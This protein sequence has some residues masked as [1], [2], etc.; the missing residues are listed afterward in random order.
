MKLTP[1]PMW[2]DRF[3]RWFAPE[4]LIAAMIWAIPVVAIVASLGNS[5]VLGLVAA[6]AL[7][8]RA[9]RAGAR[10]LVASPVGWAALAYLGWY[11]VTAAWSPL[12][13]HGVRAVL[14]AMLIAAGGTLLLALLLGAPERLQR[15]YL[16]LVAVS[17]LAFVVAFVVGM[18]LC[19]WLPLPPAMDFSGEN[20]VC[21]RDALWRSSPLLGLVALPYALAIRRRFGW[22]AA[23]AFAAIVAAGLAAHFRF[24]GFLAFAVALCSFL[25]VWVTGW[26]GARLTG[27]L[28]AIW[29]LLAPAA[30]AMLLASPDFQAKLPEL[31]QSWQERS[32]IWTRSLELIDEAPILGKGTGFVKSFSNV[33]GAEVII[34]RVNGPEPWTLRFY[35]AHS[36][37]INLRL[38][39][40]IVGALLLAALV[41]AIAFRITATSRDRLTMAL[42]TALLAGVAAVGTIG[43]NP[44]YDWWLTTIWSGILLT[45]AASLGARSAGLA[46]AAPA[47]SAGYSGASPRSGTSPDRRSQAS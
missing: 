16:T 19:H 14:E 24:A 46:G 42:G 32:F 4:I 9:V 45:A 28:I 40:G 35:D 1:A 34:Y 37:W 11:L 3:D 12:P 30:F 39:T 20:R 15:R 41:V 17:G 18:S 38:E 22:P 26:I 21:A 10:R 25:L 29:I 2:R 27:L 47:L 7:T 44:I 6:A 8:Q 23:L 31:P 33:R 43:L 36:N 5:L 13:V